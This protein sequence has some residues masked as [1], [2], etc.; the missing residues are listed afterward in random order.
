MATNM[1]IPTYTYSGDG[2]NYGNSNEHI[3]VMAT[4]MSILKYTLL[5]MTLNMTTPMYTYLVM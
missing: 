1:A 2:N 4:N 3:A 5:L